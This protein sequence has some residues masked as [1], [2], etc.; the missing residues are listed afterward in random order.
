MNAKVFICSIYF[1]VGLPFLATAQASA[2]DALETRASGA[3][4]ANAIRF[5]GI[6]ADIVYYDPAKPPPPLELRTK[7][8]APRTD[9]DEGERWISPD[10]VRTIFTVVV[11]LVIFGIAYLFAVYGGR[12]PVA[13]L[14]KPGEGGLG[15]KAGESSADEAPEQEPTTIAAILS[16]TDRREALLTLCRTL[17]VRTV[18]DEGVLFQRSWTDREALR[19]IPMKFAHLEALRALVLASEKVHFGGRDVTEEELRMHLSR[20]EPLWRTAST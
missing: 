13:F 6:D 14:P 16:M 5:R 8:K 15:A 11:T 4:Y 1:V 19:R 17:L 12:L 7:P 10:T 2:L 3:A 18:A 20:L 9:D